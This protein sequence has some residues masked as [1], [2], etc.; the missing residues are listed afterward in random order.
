MKN[1]ND[2]IDMIRRELLRRGVQKVT[3]DMTN[4][5]RSYM[6]HGDEWP[7]HA[8]WSIQWYVK[9]GPGFTINRDFVDKTLKEKHPFMLFAVNNSPNTIYGCG[10]HK[11]VTT[12][13]EHFQDANGEW[14]YMIPYK[15]CEIWCR[16]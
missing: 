3:V 5:N 7:Y 2:M 15:S 14:V 12:A 1:G 6:V 13:T 8:K 9:A 4:G 10:F 11:F 16:E